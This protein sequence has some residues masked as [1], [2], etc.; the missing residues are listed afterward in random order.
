MTM[1]RKHLGRF[2]RQLNDLEVYHELDKLL[3]KV[4]LERE[5]GI[6]RERGREEG[7]ACLLWNYR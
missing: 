2:T 3:R 7:R 1:H 5:G 6:E 4:R